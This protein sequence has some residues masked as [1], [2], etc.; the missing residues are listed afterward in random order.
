MPPKEVK[1]TR[2]DLL[3]VKEA[4][5]EAKRTVKGTRETVAKSSPIVKRCMGEVAG[6]LKRVQEKPYGNAGDGGRAEGDR[7]R[8]RKDQA[9]SRSE[10]AIGQ[11]EGNPEKAASCIIVDVR[12]P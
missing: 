2:K 4:L 5:A 6:M 8:Q 11:R 9:P 1:V 7:C 12:G 10:E 3:V